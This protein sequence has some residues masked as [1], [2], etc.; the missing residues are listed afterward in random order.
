M[1]QVLFR[2]QLQPFLINWLLSWAA[3][4][5]CVFDQWSH[6]RPH[7]LRNT[8]INTLLL[9]F[10]FFLFFFC[11][12]CARPWADTHW[13]K[14]AQMQ[15]QLNV[16]DR[17]SLPES[18]ICIISCSVVVI[19]RKIKWLVKKSFMLS[20]FCFPFCLTLLEFI[21][22]SVCPLRFASLIL[23]SILKDTR[24]QCQGMLCSSAAAEDVELLQQLIYL[25]GKVDYF[26]FFVV[27][28]FIVGR[29][30][31]P[32]SSGCFCAKKQLNSFTN[33]NGTRWMSPGGRMLQNT[34]LP[35]GGKGNCDWTT[36]S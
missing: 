29:G 35:Y 21:C 6:R 12:C 30:R 5:A 25:F 1:L 17:C 13:H 16:F 11:C 26:T 2:F 22:S 4:W 9:S 8:T 15:N 23:I 7:T 31:H 3:N 34:L 36:C 33:K 19:D 24:R 28:L 32:F 27:F 10:F 14:Q 20:L 18:R